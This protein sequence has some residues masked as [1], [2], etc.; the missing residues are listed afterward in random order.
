MNYMVD[1]EIRMIWSYE[2]LSLYSKNFALSIKEKLLFGL[3]NQF[4]ITPCSFLFLF[5]YFAN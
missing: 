4:D 3:D 2:S 5:I 1:N